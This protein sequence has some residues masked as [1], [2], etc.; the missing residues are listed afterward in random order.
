MNWLIA[1]A[2]CLAAVAAEGLLSGDASSHL[3][4]I[5]QPRWA[6]P[7]AAWVVI[8]LFYY[9]ACFFALARI[10]AAGLGRIDGAAAFAILLLILAANAGFNWVFFKR[11]DF[12]MAFFYY[13]PYLALVATLIWLLTRIDLTTALVFAA[14]A[15][16][17][18]Y[19][20][21]WSYRVWKMN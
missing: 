16:Y 4:Q 20:L 2:I 14:Y 5:K 3:R 6:L 19:A 17:L 9:A 8:G 12:R 21:Y 7:L 18:P 15:C 11:R 10:L 1:G 13:F